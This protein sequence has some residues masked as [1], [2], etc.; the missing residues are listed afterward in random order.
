MSRLTFLVG[1]RRGH[2]IPGSYITS[3]LTTHENLT[4]YSYVSIYTVAKNPHFGACYTCFGYE[5]KTGVM[6]ISVSFQFRSMFSHFNGKL[7]PRPF[8]WYGWTYAFLE[9]ITK[10]HLR[11][12]FK[13]KTAGLAFPKTGVS[14]LYYVPLAKLWTGKVTRITRVKCTLKRGGHLSE[15][16]LEEKLRVFR[17]WFELQR[18]RTDS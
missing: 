6:C 9:K 8:E 16:K 15:L 11:F 1:R 5:T 12:G 14:F 18:N 10:Y 3:N 4:G 2:G 17:E 7:S 13:P